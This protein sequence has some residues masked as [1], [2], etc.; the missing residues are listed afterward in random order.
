MSSLHVGQHYVCQTQGA[1]LVGTASSVNT[2]FGSVM[3][4]LTFAIQQP[5]KKRIWV[6]PRQALINTTSVCL[7]AKIVMQCITINNSAYFF[8]YSFILLPYIISTL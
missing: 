6:A 4:S 2:L 3:V 8:S 1:H 7:R 5:T